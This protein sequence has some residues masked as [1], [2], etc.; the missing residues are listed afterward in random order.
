MRMK[1]FSMFLAL[2]IV[3]FSLS[4]FGQG[5][6]ITKPSAIG[7]S[8]VATHSKNEQWAAAGPGFELFLR[9]DLSPSVFL[10]AGTGIRT[11]YDDVLTYSTSRS[12]LFPTID[13]KVGYN[14]IKNSS[15]S[16]YFCAGLTGFGRRDWNS[17]TTTTSKTFYDV[18]IIAGG[19]IQLKF[20]NSMAF[21][22]GATYNYLVSSSVPNFKYLLVAQTGLTYTFPSKMPRQRP[23]EE[24]EYPIG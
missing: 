12:T 24:I 1:S 8:F 16:P 10:S 2:G 22:L 9:Y 21:H 19:G 5:F 3:I 13:F 15:F 7:A 17:T 6:N 20:S 11:V 18:G 14:L 4:A 23:K